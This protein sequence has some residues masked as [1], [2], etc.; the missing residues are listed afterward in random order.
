MNDK[1][2][3]PRPNYIKRNLLGCLE[4]ALFMPEGAE[5]FSES[6]QG[7]MRSLFIPFLVLPVTA[8]TF[9]AAHPI[10]LSHEATQAMAAIY[11]VRTILYLACFM[12]FSYIMAK[13]LDRLDSFY[14]LTAA[15]NW[16]LLPAAI[17]MLPL[18]LAFIN[19][20]Y[21]WDE[22]FPLIVFITFYFYA[23]LAYMSTKVLNIPLELGIFIA[24]AS[25]ALNQTALDVVKFIGIQLAQILA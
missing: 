24:A 5:R 3:Y 18:S 7:M 10:Q 11:L 16:L 1:A 2:A 6:K 22:V 14:K 8:I 12:G 17:L 25:M 19:G 21:S 20:A 9:I 23:Y 13:S 15:H 4:T